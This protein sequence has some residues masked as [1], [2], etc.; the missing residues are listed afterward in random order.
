[1][2]DRINNYVC[3]Q[4]G[5]ILVTRDVDEGVTPFM[6]GCLDCPGYGYSMFYRPKY[7]G[8]VRGEW[9]RP[10]WFQRLFLSAPEKEH[11]KMG[12]LLFRQVKE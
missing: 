11:V 10:N 8:P 2:K 9:Y 7:I 1:V 12:G 5:G 6:K 3:Q 4:C